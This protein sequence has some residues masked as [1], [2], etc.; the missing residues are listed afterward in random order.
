MSP[1]SEPDASDT[2]TVSGG[3]TTM[4]ATDELLAEAAVLGMVHRDAEDWAEAL[5]RIRALDKSPVPAWRPGD[6]GV[7]LLALAGTVDA[8]GE[9]SRHLADS[10]TSAAESYGW[11]ERQAQFLARLSAAGMASALGHLAPALLL[12]AVPSV[13]SAVLGWLL[14]SIVTPTAP[15]ESARRVAA[16]VADNPR[17]LTNP[18][19]VAMVRAAVSSADD[20]AGGALGMPFGLSVALGDD[21][22]RMLGVPESAGALLLAAR[23]GGALRETPVRVRRAGAGSRSPPPSGMAGLAVRIPSAARPGAPQVRIERYGT[24]AR[25]AWVVYAGGTAAWTPAPGTEP[26]DATSNVTAVAEQRSGSYRGVVAAMREAGIQPADPVIGVGHSQGGLVMAQVAAS[27]EFNTV[28]VATFGA[29]AGQIEIADD[30]PVIAVEHAD[31]LVPALGGTPR[32][33]TGDGNQHLVVRR[34]VFADRDPPP[35]IALP[36]HRMGAYEETA[37]LI[38]VSPEPRLVEFRSRLVETLGVEPGETGLWR[39]TRVPG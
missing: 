33:T 31:D 19:L 30:V 27:G 10:L 9:E 38:D 16:M 12:M 34:E 21:G 28:G 22:L 15:A 13:T 1:S 18:L 6:A 25:P 37:R 5:R 32:D 35:G 2:L 24:A 4:V 11:V 39:V 8:I 23:A 14:A 3:G 29:P 20:A 17:I 26:W 7:E 36:A